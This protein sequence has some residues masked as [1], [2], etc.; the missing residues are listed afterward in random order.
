MN[1]AAELNQ[2][3]NLMSKE[4]LDLIETLI[5]LTG[6]P[7]RNKVKFEIIQMLKTAGCVPADI[8]LDQVRFAILQYL[9]KMNEPS[10]GLGRVFDA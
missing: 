7:D 4:G 8:D 10:E 5:E 6:L 9:D 3:E 2:Y 1:N